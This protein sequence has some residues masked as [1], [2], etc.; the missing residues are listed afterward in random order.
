M[1]ALELAQPA[2]IQT[3]EVS[4][5]VYG[6]SYDDYAKVDA[7]NGSKIVN[8]RRSPKYYRHMIDNPPAESDAMF[9]GTVTHR[10]I[11]EPETVGKIAV[12]GTEDWMKTRNGKKWDE[13]AKSATDEGA[14]ILTVKEYE[15]V[16]NMTTGV[17][18]N[19]PIRKYAHAEGPTEVCMFWRDRGRKYKARLDKLIPATHTIFDL[20][21]TRD[22]HSWKFGSQAYALGYHIKMALYA[23]GYA[24]IM[25]RTP[26]C[27]IGA[28]D[29][30]A[31]YES[32]VYRMT[33][34]VLQQGV[35]E[36]VALVKLIDECEE[37]G[38][39]PGE[40]DEETDLFLPAWTQYSESPADE[41]ND[42]V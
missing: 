32:A 7:L 35:D 25:G 8:M 18:N 11:L 37:S 15:G 9:L 17:L 42:A 4:G 22:C 14:L 1:S 16:L 30:K 34:D 21:T 20:K 41:T 29:S 26:V 2:A 38:N 23:R 40:Y 24:A 33:P 10:A 13:W 6:M 36:M 12:W 31:P 5:F 28:I 3:A 39:W 27:R 19:E